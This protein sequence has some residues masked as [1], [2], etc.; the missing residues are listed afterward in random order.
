MSA[1]IDTATASAEGIRARSRAPPAALVSV[2]VL[3]WALATGV[4]AV[5]F[6][7]YNVT[8]APGLT[9][10]S[11]DGTELATVPHQLG[12]LHSP[13][14]PF[15]TWVGKLFTC[16]PVGDVAYRMNLLSAVG[17]ARG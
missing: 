6:V 7:V 10:A 8:L 9:Y 11:L 2:H 16:L 1:V 3:D 17:A 13:G 12:L 14:Y 5:S 4:F 15:Y